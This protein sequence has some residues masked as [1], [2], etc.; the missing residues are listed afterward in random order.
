[1]G[2]IQHTNTLT[3]TL[4]NYGATLLVE[5]GFSQPIEFEAMT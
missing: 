2:I 3:T 5:L 4:T 1:M